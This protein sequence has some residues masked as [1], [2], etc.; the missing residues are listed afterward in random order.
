MN[1]TAVAISSA[2]GSYVTIDRE[3]RSGDQI[4]ARFPMHLR[5]EPLPGHA[6]TVAVFDGPILLA[7][8]LGRAGL[9]DATRYDTTTPALAKLPPV[10]IPAFVPDASGVLAHVTPAD[11]P[12]TFV[13]TGLGQPHDVRLIP[14]F[15]ASATRYTVY[16]QVF[17]PDEWTAHS[18]RAAAD[19]ETRRRIEQSTI[20]IVDADSKAS[21]QAHDGQGLDD[22]RRPWFEGRAGRESKTT[23]F[24]YTLKVD[25]ARR[26]R[27]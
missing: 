6:K 1:G 24:G 9:S 14:F 13:T 23:P 3:W 8:D 19:A 22:H 10:D 5:T 27:W 20:D 18:R 17:T 26:C 16:W 12:L 11:A 4:V 15:R 2:P 7:G 25:G 21:E